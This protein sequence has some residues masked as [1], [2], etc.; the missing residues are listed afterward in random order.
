MSICNHVWCV[1]M[2]VSVCV[3]ACVCVCA[4]CLCNYNDHCTSDQPGRTCLHEPVH[5][6]QGRP[7]LARQLELAIFD[8]AATLRD[9]P[10]NPVGGRLRFPWPSVHC[11]FNNCAEEGPSDTWLAKHIDSKH[12]E[13]FQACRQIAQQLSFRATNFEYYCAAVREHERRSLPGRKTKGE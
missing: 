9:K 5:I 1:T 4:S 3:C 2:R 6:D 13:V 8:V 12:S 10:L 7:T 11:A